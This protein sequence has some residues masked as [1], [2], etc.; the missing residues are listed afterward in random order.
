[1]QKSEEYRPPEKR[2]C[3][4]PHNTGW[5]DL[6]NYDEKAI[7]SE[8]DDDEVYESD[9]WREIISQRQRLSS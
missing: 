7:E 3:G 2:A 9:N 4:R 8:G 5:L 1:M 6:L